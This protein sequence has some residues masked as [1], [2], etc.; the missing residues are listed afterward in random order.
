MS[1]DTLASPCPICGSD[2]VDITAKTYHCS[3][4]GL[5]LK[6]K[7]SLLPFKAKEMYQVEAIGSDYG[8]TQ[9]GLLKQSI[10][11]VDLK[12]LAESVYTDAQLSAFASGNYDDINMPS[13]TVAQI[14]LEQLRET[15]Y[16][17]INGIK[18]AFGPKLENGGNRF[19]TGATKNLAL[20]WQDE[21]N[22]FLTNTRL[23]FPS[24]KFTFIRLDRRVTA[25]Q[26]FSDGIAL[27]ERG[28]THAS[29]FIGCAAHQAALA[30]AYIMGKVK[31]LQADIQP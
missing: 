23:V 17:Q 26:T 9:T 11:P 21:G 10:S 24:N 8:V 4:C 27:Q 20:D 7:K 28:A 25:L 16:I 18:R 2:T 31:G 30:G 6:A 22:L 1:S 12:K 3:Q 29:Y 13:E 5:R 15:C 14:L 19:P